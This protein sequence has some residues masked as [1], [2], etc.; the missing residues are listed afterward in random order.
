MSQ[1]CYAPG[2]SRQRLALLL[3]SHRAPPVC[4]AQVGLFFEPELTV[5]IDL[6]SSSEYQSPRC[7]VMYW[8]LPKVSREMSVI[9]SFILGVNIRRRCEH[10]GI[11]HDLFNQ[12]WQEGLTVITVMLIARHVPVS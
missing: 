4:Q 12:E 10:R 5:P 11:D 8:Y 2:L 9:S 1:N 7:I 6:E 3:A